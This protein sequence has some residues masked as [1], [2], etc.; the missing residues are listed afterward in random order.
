MVNEKKIK[1]QTPPPTTT[2]GD[3]YVAKTRERKTQKQWKTN[4]Y[5]QV[6]DYYDTKCT[7]NMQRFS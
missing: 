3:Q 6:Y 4:K 5:I 1:T 7:L 2:I